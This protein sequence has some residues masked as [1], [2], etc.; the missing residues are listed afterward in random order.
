[1][2]VRIST[3]GETGERLSMI[4]R[5]AGNRYVSTRV[6]EFFVKCVIKV[7]TDAGITI[8]NTFERLRW[9][10]LSVVHG[11]ARLIPLTTP[12]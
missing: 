9:I 3:G 1:M 8:I 2:Q 12:F 6:C 5:L 7:R 10:N 11:T 4:I